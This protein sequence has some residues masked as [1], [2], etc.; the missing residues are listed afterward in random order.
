MSSMRQAWKTG[1]LTFF[2]SIAISSLSRFWTSH[3]IFWFSIV[4][5]F[6]VIAVGIVF[7]IIGTAVTAARET[8]YHAMAADKVW[9]A[10]RAIWLVRRADRVANFCNDVVGDICGTASG[11][12]N[13]A[14]VFD[15]TTRYY[16]GWD[17]NFISILSLGIVAAMTVGGKAWG[18]S[19]ALRRANHIIFRV[20]QALAAWD[21]FRGRGQANP[22]KQDMERKRKAS[23][24]KRGV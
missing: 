23:S 16:R 5:L 2:L 13:A 11:A 10:K 21:H 24:R 22:K 3:V 8:P 19:T 7:D 6:L 18:K 15:L 4:P 12:I 1:I 9:G 20:G 17:T 14:L